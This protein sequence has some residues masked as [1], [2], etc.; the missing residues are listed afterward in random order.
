MP[1]TF[2]NPARYLPKAVSGDYVPTVFDAARPWLLVFDDVGTVTIPNDDDVPFPAGSVLNV[3]QNGAGTVTVA[4]DAGVTVVNGGD[5]G[6][7]GA[8]AAVTKVD[9]NRWLLVGSLA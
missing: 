4:G 5:L 6:G 8:M 3:A 2:T 1:Q 7:E 9:T